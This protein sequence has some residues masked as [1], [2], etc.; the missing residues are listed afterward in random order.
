MLKYSRILDKVGKEWK[1]FLVLGTGMIGITTVA[2]LIVLGVER[3]RIMVVG[4]NKA[5][6]EGVRQFGVEKTYE[7]EEDIAIS[8]ELFDGYV[9]F[10]HCLELIPISIF[11]PGCNVQAGIRN[12]DCHERLI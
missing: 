12:S 1:G 4:R 3:E 2:S 10:S 8:K 5:R 7:D 9:L 6:N 11:G